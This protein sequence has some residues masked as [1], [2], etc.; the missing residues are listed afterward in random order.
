MHNQ[1]FLLQKTTCICEQITTVNMR[2]CNLCRR[3]A[4]S[5]AVEKARQERKAQQDKQYKAFL[6]KY[7]PKYNNGKLPF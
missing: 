2:P 3:Q 4:Y 5:P 6:K 1:N 7:D